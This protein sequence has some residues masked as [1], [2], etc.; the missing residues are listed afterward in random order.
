MTRSSHHGPAH[1]GLA[2]DALDRRILQTLQQNARIT[3]QA[4]AEAVNLS[5]SACLAR[6][7][8]LEAAGLILGAHAAIDIERVAPTVVVFAEVTLSSH[9]PQDFARFEQAMESL[10]A[11]VEA[12]QV[13]GH[14]DYLLKVAVPDINAWRRLADALL[15]GDYGVA[16]ITSL[17][18]MAEVK[19]FTG[20]PI[21]G[22]T[23][24]KRE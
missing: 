13:S 1:H 15:A 21:E 10:P 3:N 12:A 6:V 17:I 18:R 22:G 7:R 24:G 19:R 8:R 4:L 23:P 5:P 11:V 20:Y 14:F 2:L 16:K 9:H